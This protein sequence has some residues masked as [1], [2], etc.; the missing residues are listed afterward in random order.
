[1]Q[2]KILLQ[3][4]I[5]WC[6][7]LLIFSSSLS[8][9][10]NIDIIVVMFTRMKWS[11]SWVKL[12]GAQHVLVC[13]LCLCL[14]WL[15]PGGWRDVNSSNCCVF[16]KRGTSALWR[17]AWWAWCHCMARRQSLQERKASCNVM[18]SYVISHTGWL[19]LSSTLLKM[20]GFDMQTGS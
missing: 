17:D 3:R 12:T 13:R 2:V 10:S 9:S 5:V 19:L 6:V 7:F 16:V 11:C 20:R 14:W 4:F 15:G 1:M 18:S 8:H